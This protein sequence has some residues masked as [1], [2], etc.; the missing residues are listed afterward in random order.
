MN[1]SNDVQKSG[2]NP[3]DLKS[4][5]KEAAKLE[6]IT[7]LMTILKLGLSEAE[8]LTYYKKMDELRKNFG[9]KFISIGMSGDYIL[10]ARAHGDYVRI[11]TA[12]VGE[13]T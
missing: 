11:G 7:G 10:A 2:V 6:Q 13:R 1:I 12:I 8:T 5:I 4:F 9:L 3:D